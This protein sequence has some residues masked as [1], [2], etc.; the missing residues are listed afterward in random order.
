MCDVIKAVVF[1]K[2]K[3][4]SFFDD[5]LI[6]FIPRI[7]SAYP[8]AGRCRWRGAGRLGDCQALGGRHGGPVAG[9]IPYFRRR[10]RLPAGDSPE[11]PNAPLFDE[12]GLFPVAT[13]AGT[14]LAFGKL[15]DN[16]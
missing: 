13:P 3:Y 8:L 15:Y 2:I 5:Y 11:R 14:C 4:H 1:G 16:G 7:R 9:Y 10:D 12:Y 6:M